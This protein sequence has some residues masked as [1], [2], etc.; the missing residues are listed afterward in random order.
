MSHRLLVLASAGFA[1]GIGCGN[2]SAGKV[3]VSQS[4]A[5]SVATPMVVNAT[6]SVGSPSGAGPD[7]CDQIRDC[8][9]ALSNA[10]RLQ[11]G[12]E[13]TQGGSGVVDVCRTNWS[14]NALGIRITPLCQTS[15][16]VM[17]S[18]FADYYA[19]HST[20]AEPMPAACRVAPA[21][22]GAMPGVPAAGQTR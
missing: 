14:A 1:L 8:C 4:A 5:P 21:G 2:P 6:P 20:D 18:G 12:L 13:Q 17:Q 11:S 15:L 3:P 10:P 9:L 7:A 22:I 16:V 19:A